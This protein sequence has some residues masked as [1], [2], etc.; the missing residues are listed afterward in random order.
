MSIHRGIY[1]GRGDRIKAPGGKF[2]YRADLFP[3]EVELLDDF[4]DTGSGLEVLEDCGHRHPGIAKH[5]CA[6]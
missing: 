3:C 2:K 1:S 4:L 6:A 5:P